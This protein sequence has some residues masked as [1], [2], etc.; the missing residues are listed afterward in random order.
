MWS[1]DS[2]ILAVDNK[3]GLLPLALSLQDDPD[4]RVQ[5]ALAE[6]L[7]EYWEEYDG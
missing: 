7:E 6:S 4:D 5:M 2:G 1:Y 3:V